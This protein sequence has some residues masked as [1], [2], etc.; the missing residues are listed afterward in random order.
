MA[1]VGPGGEGRVED[2]AE[3]ADDVVADLGIEV[4]QDLLG[5]AGDVAPHQRRV[6]VDAGVR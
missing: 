4:G 2:V 6:L 1:T 5:H 3:D